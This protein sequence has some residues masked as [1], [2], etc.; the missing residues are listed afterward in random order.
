VVLR[1]LAPLLALMLA[2]C[3]S[4]STTP[5]STSLKP[6]PVVLTE[7]TT[8]VTPAAGPTTVPPVADT[9]PLLD[10]YGNPIDDSV[11]YTVAPSPA[12]AAPPRAGPPTTGP[13]PTQ[14]PTSQRP[15]CHKKKRKHCPP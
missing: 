11:T 2:G 10:V 3:A 13:R 9:A 7:T 6:L 14:P 15:V 8:T 12:T 4:E 1:R 5:T